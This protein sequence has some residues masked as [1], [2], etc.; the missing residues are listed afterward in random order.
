MMGTIILFKWTYLN[1]LKYYICIQYSM[2]IC[3]F[4]DIGIARALPFLYKLENSQVKITFYLK[5]CAKYSKHIPIYIHN[6][7]TVYTLDT[8]FAFFFKFFPIIKKL[9]NIGGFGRSKTSSARFE[10]TF[11]GFPAPILV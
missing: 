10:T 6:T 9:C 8:F 4:I 11:F 1:Q 2:I 5:H 3:V 7:T